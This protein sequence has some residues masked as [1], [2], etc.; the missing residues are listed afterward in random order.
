[1]LETFE[2]SASFKGKIIHSNRRNGKRKSPTSTMLKLKVS[3]VFVTATQKLCKLHIYEGGETADY[4]Q[5]K[6]R[7]TGKYI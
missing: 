1:M 2:F 6:R 4:V 5:K 7:K 3:C